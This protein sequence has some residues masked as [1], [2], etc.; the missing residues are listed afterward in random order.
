[1]KHYC[2]C[3][4]STV[5]PMALPSPSP[6]PLSWNTARMDLI[7]VV[8]LL[9]LLFMLLAFAEHLGPKRHHTCGN[10]FWWAFSW[11]DQHMQRKQSLQWWKCIDVESKRGLLCH[12]CSN[13]FCFFSCLPLRNEIKFNTHVNEGMHLWSLMI[14]GRHKLHKSGSTFP[15]HT[16]ACTHKH[17]NFV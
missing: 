3:W 15:H 17:T 4:F 7:V 8:V 14:C 11:S 1:M 10:S 9:L 2:K 16:H 5:V 13:N 6:S 12:I